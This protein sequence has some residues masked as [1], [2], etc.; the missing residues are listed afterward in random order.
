MYSKAE[1]AK[2]L[3]APGV[4]GTSQCRAKRGSARRTALTGAAVPPLQWWRHLPAD[5]FTGTHLQRLRRAMA[6]SA[7]RDGRKPSAATRPPPSR[8]R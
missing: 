2:H 3:T 6:G 8:S 5:A 4:S 1:K 7:S